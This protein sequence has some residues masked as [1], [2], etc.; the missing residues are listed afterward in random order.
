V[1]SI[2][3]SVRRYLRRRTL[4]SVGGRETVLVVCRDERDLALL[5]DCGSADA[6]VVASDDMT[7]RDAASGHPSVAEVTHFEGMGTIFD[8]D[9]TVIEIRD[10]VNLWLQEL[11]E[12]DPCHEDVLFWRALP[13]GGPTHRILDAVLLVDSVRRLLGEYDPDTVVLPRSLERRFDD[14]VISHTVEASEARLATLN[15]PSAAL[16]G[17]VGADSD[18]YFYARHDKYPIHQ[19]ALWVA[20]PAKFLA[21][22]ARSRTKALLG[23]DSLVPFDA[24]K[25]TVVLHHRGSAE[26]HLKDT[27]AVLPRVSDMAG[28]ESRV[29]TWR[30]ERGRA[31]VED[32]GLETVP[33]E[34]AVP[35]SLAAG[36]V[37]ES[38]TLWRR[39]VER[40]P[41]LAQSTPLTYDGVELTPVL[42]PV[43]RQ[44]FRQR[45]PDRIALWHAVRNYFSENA[46]AAVRYA[47]GG[48]IVGEGVVCRRSLSRV[49]SPFSFTYRL[50]PNHIPLPYLESI[51]SVNDRYFAAGD[52]EEKRL[53]EEN[54]PRSRVSKVGTS[55]FD[56]VRTIQAE[57]SKADSLATI[58]L[59]GGD[60]DV[61]FAPQA[62]RRGTFT[63]QEKYAVTEGLMG[64]ASENPSLT[65]F[66][67]PHPNDSHPTLQTCARDYDAENV[68]LLDPSVPALH[69]I[70]A[71]DIVVT[72][73]SL[74]GFEAMLMETP[75]V[76]VALDDDHWFQQFG[77]AADR[78][79]SVDSLVEFLTDLLSSPAEREAWFA[80]QAEAI[81][82]FT[83]RNLLVTDDPNARIVDEVGSA[84]RGDAR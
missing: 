6:V 66:V 13:E 80:E 74:T 28:F 26:K 70:N 9:E 43:V 54:V 49:R 71:A 19:S 10:R 73:Y 3:S 42:W 32:A 46:P 76:S 20:R 82:R 78:F 12:E 62:G 25:D 7:V 40:R 65:L 61:Y 60:I 39:A 58:G 84:V 47:G 68:T 18:A 57:S 17:L 2:R 33:L 72:K 67:K 1:D 44:F 81:E 16:M 14:R 50:S 51:H 52:L 23:D 38:R 56:D 35:T 11:H 64:C 37:S 27:T 48:F 4:S 5:S 69:C 8:V 15:P 79:R 59:D 41:A 22:M 83:E 24:D 31:K 36:A 34:R 30:D 53:V 45:V 29:V 75:V 77:D 55:Q 63:E 21:A